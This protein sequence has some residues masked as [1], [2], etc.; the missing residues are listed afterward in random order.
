MAEQV[1]VARTI[2]E[3]SLSLRALADNPSELEE[4][5]ANGAVKVPGDAKGEKAMMLRV[6]AQPHSGSS[7][8]ATGA[9]E[10]AA[11]AVL[12]QC[13]FHVKT[14]I[15][16]LSK[17]TSVEQAQALLEAAHGSVRQALA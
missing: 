11:R 7:S 3:L 13:G 4:A 5:I 14:A 6:A 16:A 17:Q 10:E 8:F 12:E 15:V 1:A 2:G 9:D